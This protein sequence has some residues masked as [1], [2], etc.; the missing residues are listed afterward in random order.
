MLDIYPRRYWW[1]IIIGK[2]RKAQKLAS[3]GDVGPLV[4]PTQ[5]GWVQD[6]P[7]AGDLWA[8]AVNP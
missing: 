8:F 7:I 2:A 5:N 1:P 3:V 6:R 4:M